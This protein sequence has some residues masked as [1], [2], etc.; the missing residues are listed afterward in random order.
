MPKTVFESFRQYA[1]NLEITDRQVSI[2][3]NCRSNVVAVL[4]K[5][6]SLHKEESKVIGSWDR[7]TLIRY[8]SE[9]DVDIMV[10]LHYGDNKHLDTPKGTK[11]VLDLF[12]KSL[13]SSYPNTEMYVDDNCVTMKLTEFNLDIVPAF[14]LTTGT[15][16]IPDIQKMQWIQTNPI[17]FQELITKVNKTMDGKFVPLV[18]M[19]KGWNRAQKYPIKGFH[20]E[21]IMYNR[22]KSYT[23]G[24][25]YDSMINVFFEN[26]PYYLANPSYDPITGVRVDT[27]LNEGTRRSVAI[28]KA[29]TAAVKSKE[30]YKDSTIYA[31]N[32]SI[33]ISE[34]K[35]LLGEFFPAY[36]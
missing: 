21:C 34:W 24:Y 23:K 1:S 33:S 11:D 25:T 26:L 35:T 36:S 7:N 22:Y 18:K 2:V 17:K 14:K 31:T 10:I 12:L 30:A 16:K 15:F 28:Q 8:L 13:K 29:K 32:L 3:A 4:E 20:L 6:F 27:Y 5:E 9:G 19:I